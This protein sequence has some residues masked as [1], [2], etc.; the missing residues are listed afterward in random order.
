MKTNLSPIE[1]SFWYQY[2]YDP[3]SDAQ[4]IIHHL[5][6]SNVYSALQ[7]KQ[8]MQLMLH[9]HAILRA[10]FY[11]EGGTPYRS[12]N[13]GLSFEYI[14]GNSMPDSILIGQAQRFFSLEE[15]SLVRV[16]AKTTNKS[17]TLF[18]TIPHIIFDAFSWAI[19]INEFIDY[20]KVSKSPEESITPAYPDTQENSN[21]YWIHQLK[22]TEGRVSLEHNP[23]AKLP[24]ATLDTFV[25]PNQ[26]ALFIKLSEFSKSHGLSMNTLCMAIFSL[27]L[28]KLTDTRR[29]IIATPVTTRDEDNMKHIGSY[30]NVLPSVI[31]SKPND[32][33]L[34]YAQTIASKVWDDIDNRNFSLIDIISM[35]QTA[36]YDDGQGIYNVMAEYT[37][38]TMLHPDVIEDEL[39]QNTHTKLDIILSVIAGVDDHVISLEYDASKLSRDY[40]EKIVETFI[41]IITS[42]LND[43]RQIIESIELVGAREKEDLL[44]LGRGPLKDI[45]PPFIWNRFK[46]VASANSNLIAVTD[47]VSTTSYGELLKMAHKYAGH[48]EENGVGEKS[49]VGIH[50]DRGVD[51]VASMLALWSLGAIY[52]PLDLQQ[53]KT[54][55]ESMVKQAGVDTVLIKGDNATSIDTVPNLD[56]TQATNSTS[57]DKNH[58]PLAGDTAYIIFTSGSTGTPKGVIIEHAGFLN[59]L[60]IMIDEFN[61]RPGDVVAQ[62]APPSFDISVWQLVGV[63]IVGA[64]IVVVEHSQL[65]DPDEMYR[66][67]KNESVSI[68]EIVP[69]LISGYLS[70]ETGRA[71]LAG[72]L[73]DLKIITT[74]EAISSA[75]VSQWTTA[76][77]STPLHNAYGPAEGSDDT[78]MYV[79]KKDNTN[80]THSIP[81]GKPLQN[82]HTYLLNYEM[83]LTPNGI[84]GEICI[85]GLVVASGYVND[86]ESTARSFLPNTLPDATGRL[87]RTGDYGKWNADGTLSY[88]GRRDHQVKVRGQRLEIGEV[89]EQLKNIPGI[90]DAAIIAQTSPSGTKLSGYI[91][92][93]DPT[94]TPNAAKTQL[95]STL[96][97]YMVPHTIE[98]LERLERG[99]NGKLDRKALENRQPQAQKTAE[100]SVPTQNSPTLNT[101][102]E[103]YTEVLEVE[104]A[105]K[106][107]YFDCGGDSLQSMRITSLLANRG[108]K[109]GIRD[110]LL[111]QT[112]LE[113]SAYIEAELHDNIQDSSH[114][115]PLDHPTPIQQTYLQNSNEGK[116]GADEMQV[117]ILNLDKPS[118]PADI[119]RHL[120]VITE[121]HGELK[122]LE[123]S[124]PLI[125]EDY[126]LSK[127][128][129]AEIAELIRKDINLK[130]PLI[131][132]LLSGQKLLLVAHHYILDFYSWRLLQEELTALMEDPDTTLQ[133]ENIL[134]K[135]WGNTAQKIKEDK[136]VLESARYL[137]KPINTQPVQYQTAKTRHQT[138]AFELPASLI[139]S[140]NKSTI[141]LESFAYYIYGLSAAVTNKQT[142]FH[143]LLESS[144]RTI[145]TTNTLQRG[146]GWMTYTFP[147]K[148][149]SQP[150]SISVLRKFHQDISLSLQRGYE[151]GLLRH[152]VYPEDYKNTQPPIW[153]LNYLGPVIS[154]TDTVQIIRTTPRKNSAFV[155]VDI[156]FD[157]NKLLFDHYDNISLDTSYF[158]VL[159]N[160]ITRLIN[161][162]INQAVTPIRTTLN[163]ERSA[164]ILERL[165]NA[166]R[167]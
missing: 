144:L 130:N 59:H 97:E 66:I 137:W 134:K 159:N 83:Q 79:I 123:S 62:T 140:L 112:P 35:T 1:L 80:S 57:T 24:P 44:L 104:V 87:Y 121:A 147:Q 139:T 9:K 152:I 26:H 18:I 67:I 99:I 119:L 154:N 23:D 161:S 120:S 10:R 100:V 115:K 95:Q 150:E 157:N 94:L 88:H 164:A 158:E 12:I 41:V 2:R 149:V 160:E 34:E 8:S 113:L 105:K 125:V 77:P 116:N 36:H 162:L 135:W 129:P 37:P 21:T 165:R 111:Y 54:R 53:P 11:E 81:I 74:G 4:N 72:R 143:Y 138:M 3:L 166:N 56:I 89:E 22:N 25:R 51:Y 136:S 29:M 146:I 107:N 75:V 55:L 90:S 128:T 7:V 148:I 28:S 101:I 45:H 86:L 43:P 63:L 163:E 122:P 102:M 38:L 78:H 68:L 42:V 92:V 70:N 156:H 118:T 39:I 109:V 117:V 16:I 98:I 15:G 19:F 132:C 133:N 60:E 84:I 69:S 71:D 124:A 6:I 145:D 82:V 91:A 96:P 85:G 76:Y 131:G 27:T 52:V 61:I 47:S 110:I 13:D 73:K 58:E 65:I 142:D 103:I 93:N 17:T 20:L 30:I 31:E 151:Y 155:E 153:L 141:S 40:I 127:K 106:S 32:S 114:W 126:F 14:D 33:F 5:V 64:S 48:L 108:I 49:I 50:M 46:K 167:N